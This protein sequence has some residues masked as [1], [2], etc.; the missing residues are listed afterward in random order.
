MFLAPKWSRSIAIYDEEGFR[1]SSPRR[2]FEIHSEIL[3]LGHALVFWLAPGQ[4]C[5]RVGGS[6]KQGGFSFGG[7][8]SWEGVLFSLGTGLECVTKNKSRVR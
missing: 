2:D 7:G 6:A 3:A 5:A 1:Q 4:A 8:V